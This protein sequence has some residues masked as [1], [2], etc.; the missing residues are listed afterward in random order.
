MTKLIYSC[1]SHLSLNILLV[2]VLSLKW[3]Y[4][5][6]NLYICRFVFLFF[7][8]CLKKLIWLSYFGAHIYVPAGIKHVD[9]PCCPCC[10]PP[11]QNAICNIAPCS[12]RD[13]YAYWDIFHPTQ[14]IYSIMAELCFDKWSSNCDSY[15]I[16][17]LAKL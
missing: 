12:N 1:C 15:S 16:K 17:Q 11:A 8:F 10:I 5:K 13:D 3:N 9:I 14:K 4:K 2:R 6:L 7:R